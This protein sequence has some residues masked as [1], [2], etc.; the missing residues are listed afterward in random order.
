MLW[1]Y[2]INNYGLQLNNLVQKQVKKH[3][4]FILFFVGST[5]ILEH[6]DFAQPNSQLKQF[7]NIELVTRILVVST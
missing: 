2:L 7:N 1:Y 3:C 4:N 5:A 6:L